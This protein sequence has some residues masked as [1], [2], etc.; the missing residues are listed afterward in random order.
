MRLA[1]LKDR[2]S[3]HG[4]GVFTSSFPLHT[5]QN[6]PGIV[7]ELQI[8][9][10][11]TSYTQN[12]RLDHLVVENFPLHLS[13]PNKKNYS[14]FVLKS[15]RRRN[16]NFIYECGARTKEISRVLLNVVKNNYL[17][18]LLWFCVLT[19]DIN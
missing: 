18:F 15:I 5:R 17:E 6:V 11:R 14:G 12:I 9:R 8:S 2:H 10:K 16:C 13:L 1:G 7:T 3:H 4:E 19:L